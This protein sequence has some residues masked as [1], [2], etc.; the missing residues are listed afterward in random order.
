MKGNERMRRRVSEAA[1]T[2]KHEEEEGGQEMRLMRRRDPWRLKAMP[3][4]LLP[5]T[6]L[7][8][9]AC[10][11]REKGEQVGEA[12]EEA[13][14][15]VA[16]ALDKPETPPVAEAKVDGG[17]V[18]QVSGIVTF[19]DSIGGVLVSAELSGLEPGEHGFHVH[20]VGDCGGDGFEAAGGHFNPEGVQHGNALDPI[21]HAGDLG[22]IVA[23]DQG[24]ASYS[25]EIG[26]ISLEEGEPN[27][28]V[29]KAII[30]HQGVDDFETQPSGA[31][32]PRIAC[33]VIERTEGA[34]DASDER[35]TT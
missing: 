10:A 32:G 2:K 5:A 15:S 29:G 35:S 3:L 8:A 11:P 24:L 23:D 6:L 14:S 30:V 34:M 17:D 21:H 13:T 12:I 26:G 22:N 19:V 25:K 4:L 7:L 20:E 27:S 33:G 28:V 18:S 31:S 16:N 1:S 9:L